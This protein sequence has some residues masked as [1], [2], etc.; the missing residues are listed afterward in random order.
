MSNHLTEDQI[1]RW[2]VGR[3]TLSE[4]RHVQACGPCTAELGRFLDTLESF[5]GVISRRAE[6]LTAHGS[7]SLE[8]VLGS[9]VTAASPSIL[10]SLKR[11]LVD[12]FRPAR[13]A[14][15]GAAAQEFEIGEIWSKNEFRHARWLSLVVHAVVIGLLVIPPVVKSSLEPTETVVTL[16]RSVPL[17]LNFPRSEQEKGGGGGGGGRKALTPPSRGVPPRGADTQLVPPMVEPKN[18]MPELVVEP[19]VI[20][21]QLQNFR[22]LDLQIGDPAGVAGPLSAGPGKGGGIGTG[23]GTGVGPGRGPGVGDGENGGVGGGLYTLG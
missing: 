14:K 21:Q 12:T 7:P 1:S 16:Y 18:L 9:E 8:M 2:F 4:Q 23:V 19:T 10:T 13:T 6:R 22:P 15:T 5:K 20:A 11:L 3:S 17:I